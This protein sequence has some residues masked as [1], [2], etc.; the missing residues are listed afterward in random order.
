MPPTPTPEFLEMPDRF[1][2]FRLIPLTDKSVLESLKHYEKQ[3]LPL[4]HR[5]KQH[6]VSAMLE[7]MKED[8]SILEFSSW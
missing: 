4:H 8:V 7:N 1:S 3:V 5:L 6:D 2:L